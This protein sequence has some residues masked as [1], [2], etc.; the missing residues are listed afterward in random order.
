MVKEKID[1]L[2]LDDDRFVTDVLK[3]SFD[4][5]TVKTFMSAESALKSF[6][7]YDYKIAVVDFHLPK[8]DGIEVTKIIKENFP[9]TSVIIFTG[10]TDDI[11]LMIKSYEAGAINIIEKP[12]KINEF[13]KEIMKVLDNSEKIKKELEEGKKLLTNT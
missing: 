4:K 9:K 2:L 3:K 10:I 7:K 6:E 1:L 13:K 12:C 5:L 11:E 8:M